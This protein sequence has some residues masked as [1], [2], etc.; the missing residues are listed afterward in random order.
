[1]ELGS[2]P[3]AWLNYPTIMVPLKNTPVTVPRILTNVGPAETYTATVHG[4]SW[5]DIRV[6]PDTLVFSEPGEKKAVN[7]TVT[8]NGGGLKGTADGDFVE[9]SLIWVSTNHLVRSPIVAV[10]GLPDHGL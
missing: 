9:G 3:E 7:V 8:V 4:P 2:I 1:M 6:S 10:I 5:M